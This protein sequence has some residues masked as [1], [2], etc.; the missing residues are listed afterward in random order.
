MPFREGIGEIIADDPGC[1]EHEVKAL[2][3]GLGREKIWFRRMRV[4][5]TS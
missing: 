5:I 4:L 2:M 1:E 3:Y